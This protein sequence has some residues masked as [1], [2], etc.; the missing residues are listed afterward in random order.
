[1]LISS[2]ALNS[3]WLS[4]QIFKNPSFYLLLF[5]PEK[6]WWKYNLSWFF[7]FTTEAFSD[8][9]FWE[10]QYFIQLSFPT[11]ISPMEQIKLNMSYLKSN[12]RE[13]LAFN[14][15]KYLYYFFYV[16]FFVQFGL[17]PDF[18]FAKK[19]MFLLLVVDYY[20]YFFDFRKDST[21]V[22]KVKTTILKSYHPTIKE[23]VFFRIVGYL[24]KWHVG[25]SAKSMLTYISN[26]TNKGTSIIKSKHNQLPPG[27]FST[28]L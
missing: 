12:C 27:C 28:V 8:R 5:L 16:L 21:K 13:I 1:M 6:S 7:S 19:S 10:F 15:W 20:K 4:I 3:K 24:K 9:R 22:K 18:D 17:N 23:K 25:V 11:R 26:W 14:H 2:E